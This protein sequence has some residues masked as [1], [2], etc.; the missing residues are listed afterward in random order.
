MRLGPVT[1]SFIR[2]RGNQLEERKG[3]SKSYY[4]KHV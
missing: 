4:E 2:G 1:T 3:G